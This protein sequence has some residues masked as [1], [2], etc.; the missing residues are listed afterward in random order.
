MRY[1][2]TPK[3]LQKRL[4]IGLDLHKAIIAKIFK[5]RNN[6]MDDMKFTRKGGQDDPIQKKLQNTPT[7]LKK[8]TYN[9]KKERYFYTKI[10]QE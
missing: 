2:T 4:T 6:F 9:C 10:K 1:P 8:A 7:R 5:N 3:E